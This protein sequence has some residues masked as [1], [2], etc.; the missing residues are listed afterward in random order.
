MANCKPGMIAM[1]VCP[2]HYR[3]DLTRN[4]GR[5]VTVLQRLEPGFWYQNSGGGLFKVSDTEL[6]WEVQLD[7]VAVTA[8]GDHITR[9]PIEDYRLRPLEGLLDPSEVEE[10]EQL[11]A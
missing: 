8:N 5:V 3:P 4:L 7:S 2:P 9:G 6:T 1:I 11:Y 10:Y